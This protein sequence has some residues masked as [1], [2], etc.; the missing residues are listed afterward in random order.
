MAKVPPTPQIDRRTF[1]HRSGAL[2][3]LGALGLSGCARQVRTAAAPALPFYDAVGPIPPIRA[4]EDRIFR[5]TVCLRP[6]R[7]AGPRLDAEWVGDKFV[8]HNYGHGGSGWSLS[9]GSGAVAVRKALVNGDKNIAVIG[10]GAL[11]LTSATLLQREG[12][13]V[14]IYAKERPPFVRSSRATGS[15]TPDSRIAL[16]SA[17]S[18][19]FPAEWESMA[20]AS[21]AM[22]QSY[23]GMP[24]NPIEWTDRYALSDEEGA[25]P[26]HSRTT[27]PGAEKLDFARY[28]N[29]IHDLT[30]AMQPLPPGSHP[31]PVP[32]VSRNT[33][34]T[35]NVADYSRQLL[36]DFL[37]AGGKIETQEFHSPQDLA[38]LPQRTFINCTGYGARA[39]WSDESITPVRGQIAWLIPQE[40]VNYGLY[41]KDL[42][43]LGRR[44]GIVIQ[45]S[46]QGEASGWNDTNEAPDVEEAHS[47]VRSLQALYQR[48]ASMPA[49]RRG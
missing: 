5:I 28:Q 19:A 8:V 37:I 10:C 42:N 40:G 24:G 4:H 45:V 2:A 12:V 49:N 7:A 21:F 3:G 46:G 22:Y 27:V 15:W 11:G 31:F 30:P 43:V 34:L 9:W 17:A 36:N 48:M 32:F 13:R 1:L 23:L 20:R 39:L 29:R 25:V 44:D 38:A 14:T 6:F 18:A 41:Y 33:S 35:F 47:G 16:A 26:G